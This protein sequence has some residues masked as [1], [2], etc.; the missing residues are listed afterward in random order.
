MREVARLEAWDQVVTVEQN[1]HAM[2]LVVNNKTTG[3]TETVLFCGDDEVK[4]LR[5]FCK[6]IIKIID[7]GYSE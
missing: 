7:D 2:N 4:N 6:T 1:L 5:K 3:N